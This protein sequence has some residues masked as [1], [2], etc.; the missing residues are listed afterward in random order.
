MHTLFLV[1]ALLAGHAQQQMETLLPTH[2]HGYGPVPWEA[3]Y[4]A[5]ADA[6]AAAAIAEPL[7]DGAR[8][9]EHTLDLLVSLAWFESHFNPTAVGDGGASV[10]LFQIAPATAGATRAQLLD[11]AQA[12]PIAIRLLRQSRRICKGRPVE[13]Q[14]A[15][16]ARGGGGCSDK[17]YELS[18]HRWAKAKWLYTAHPLVP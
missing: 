12:A 4:P 11:P 2:E 9:A 17:G 18:R 8:G 14:L 15:W 16:Y 5:T 10:G 13:E 7:F 1:W 6:L 3:T